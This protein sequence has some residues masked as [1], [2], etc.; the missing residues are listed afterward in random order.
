L[1]AFGL[2]DDK[3]NPTWFTNGKPDI[4]KMLNIAGDKAAGI[5]ITKR[6]AYERA[7]FGAQGGGGFALLSDP[8]VH[9]QIKSL[10]K[11]MGSPEFKNRYSSFSE[12]YK[13]GSPMQQGRVA[14]AD[15]NIAMMDLGRNV[16]PAVTGALKD[17]DEA[18]KYIRSFMPG[19]DKDGKGGD[20]WKVGTRAL[21]GMVGGAAIGTLIPGVGTV[22]GG[23]VGG[24]GGGIVGVIEG[25]VKSSNEAAPPVDRFGREVVNTG[26][27]ASSA[28]SAMSG[29]AAAIR[30]L[31][32]AAPGG[33]FPGGTSTG[34]AQKMNFLKGP[35]GGA[36]GAR[37]INAKVHMK[38]Q[39]VGVMT[40]SIVD[41][42]AGPIQ[43][44]AYPDAMRR[45][46]RTDHSY[47]HA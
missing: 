16:L 33:V 11:E 31:L 13:E 38:K 14:I 4:F 21:E 42:A 37:V 32:G 19:A 47:S 36:G 27:A 30:G 41:S 24:I 26:N 17:F 39:F 43:G 20:K 9:E 6:A 23:V 22:A 12:A 18:L 46:A 5:P 10:M 28:Q 1:K 40:A 35:G 25:L 34:G 15:F 29:L 8:A 3:N 45:Q 7:L 2:I 44:S